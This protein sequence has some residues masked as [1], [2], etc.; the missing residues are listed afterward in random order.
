MP[1]TGRSLCPNLAPVPVAVVPVVNIDSKLEERRRKTASEASKFKYFPKVSL[2][3][4][5]HAKAL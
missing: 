1:K 3:V 5:E 2:R 4:Q